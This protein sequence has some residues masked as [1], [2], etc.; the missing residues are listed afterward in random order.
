MRR[1]SRWLIEDWQWPYAGTL[2]AGFLLVLF[3]VLWSADGLA[4]ALVFLQLPVYLVH[5]LEEH[6]AD[7][8][9]LHINQTMGRGR[10]VLSRPTVFWINALLVWVLF[11][12]VLLLSRY[13]DLSLGLIAVYLTGLNALTHI[14]T[15]LVS[16]D[17]NPGLLTAIVLMAPGAACGTFAVDDVGRPGPGVQILAIAVA[18]GV[19][20]ALIALIV[21]RIRRP[22]T[23]LG[24]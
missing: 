7:R 4:L 13:V 23:Q 11:L 24:G 3:P 21:R 17:Y 12:A 2:A 6:A 14:A 1:V 9:R 10:E 22:L 5:Q 16:R 20:T 8:F 19:H 18:V 15:A